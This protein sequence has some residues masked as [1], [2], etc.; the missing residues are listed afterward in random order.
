MNRL[1]LCAALAAALGMGM[2]AAHADTF[3]YH[4]TL[5]DSGQKADGT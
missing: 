5:Q 3:T 4:G 1:T 2:S